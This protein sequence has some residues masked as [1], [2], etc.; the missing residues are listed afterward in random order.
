MLLQNTCTW[1]GTRPVC[2]RL[3]DATSNRVSMFTVKIIIGRKQFLPPREDKVSSKGR[4]STCSGNFSKIHH[5]NWLWNTVLLK[6]LIVAQL[7]L[8]RLLWNLMVPPVDPILSQ[9]YLVHTS[10]SISLTSIII[11]LT[12]HLHLD[13]W[14]TVSVVCNRREM[15][16]LFFS[17]YDSV[18]NPK[19]LQSCWYI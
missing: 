2:S 12:F 6:K 5:N 7:V 19:V 13:N 17:S 1:C 10:P 11:T 4:N 15:K 9:M 3:G 8:P 14:W 18:L 16:I